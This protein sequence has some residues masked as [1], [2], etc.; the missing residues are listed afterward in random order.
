VILPDQ[1]STTTTPR[2]STN[3][4]QDTNNLAYRANFVKLGPDAAPPPP[5]ID[6]YHSIHS[7]EESKKIDALK[8]PK[9]NP[10]LI[11]DGYDQ[12]AHAL[13]LWTIVGAKAKSRTPAEQEQIASN[14]YHWM[15][16]PAYGHL[17]KDTKNTEVI[18]EEAWKKQ[19]YGEALFYNIETPYTNN[20]L[21]S[22]KHGTA[23]GLA[24]TD[25]AWV[26]V[27]DMLGN[28]FDDAT[29]QWRK[30]RAN[31]LLLGQE[32]KTPQSTQNWMQRV[33]EIDSQHA[34]HVD[35]AV[36]KFVLQQNYSKAADIDQFWADAIPSH[37]GFLNKATSF[38]AEQ[39]AQLPV[40]MG[41][42]ALTPAGLTASLS[43]TALGTK[44]AGYLTAGAEGLAY[45][46][47]TRKQDDPGEMW[48]DAI[49]F[50]IFHGLFDVGGL[51]LK[52]LTDIAPEAWKSKLAQRSEKLDL[53]QKGQ[54]P[55]TPAEVY[56]DHKTEVA[57]NLFV[58][59][60]ATQRAIYVD[61]LHFVEHTEGMDRDTVK[62]H[63]KDLLGMDSA[64]WAPVLS[65]AK[66]IRSLFDD[67]KLSEI[68]PGS[69]DEKYLSSRLAQLIVDAGSEMNTRVKGMS[70][71]AEVKATKNLATPA[72]KHTLEYYVSS[73][74][75]D[76]A[77]NPGAAAAVTPEQIM[78]AAQKKY[79][80][81]L[82]NAAEDAEQELE[83]KPE[84]AQNIAKRRKDPT[85]EAAKAIQKNPK[86]QIRSERTLDKYGQPAVRYSVNPDYTV[87]LK[88]YQKIAK[89]KG[90]NLRQFFEDMS[91]DDFEH[92]LSN[93]FYPKS[94]RDAKVFFEHQ[95][96]AQ[97]MQNPNFLAFMYNYIGQMP[98]EFGEELEQRLIGTMKVQKYMSGRTPTEPQLGWF[99]GAVYNHVDNFL[100]SGRWPKE[101][102]IFRSSNDTVFNS[103]KWQRKLLVEKTLQEQKNLKSMFSGI[104]NKKALSL[105]LKTHAAF[106]KLRLNEFDKADFKRR[107]L[108][109][110][111]IKAY[112]DVIADLQ[113]KTDTYDRWV[114]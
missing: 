53:A 48:R 74:K 24:S 35:Y 81:D 100:G 32:D 15:I 33:R 104:R 85:E 92:D 62:A 44:V 93:H 58:G 52:K 18:S 106:S 73:I 110:E 101:S 42:E 19:A 46:A 107:P 21:N 23:S 102:N 78:K 97:G 105:A 87:R 70:D 111:H 29:A 43:K 72:A 64:R 61:A 65:A 49:G 90:Q 17:Y 83:S 12:L 2:I 109:Q 38:V 16:M 68:A 112:D 41:M 55:A 99:S 94:L 22:L 75:A 57:N 96:T 5:P 63:A 20:W 113:T 39:V 47:A 50:G 84:K 37:G 114:Y 95:N 7:M 26:R 30:E 80:A 45:G 79:A 31:I 8:D 56:D 108:A 40:F 86:L 25:R 88:S 54:R 98:R 59:G 4:N 28:V 89:A 34:T 9:L 3:K 91:D 27:N 51:G 82:Q 76:L 71:A 14:F 60:V 36:P 69:K 11:E 103:T 10:N 67:K 1:K 13:H 6:K 66:F 77:R